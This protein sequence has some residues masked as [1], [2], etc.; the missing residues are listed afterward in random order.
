M[1]VGRKKK[2]TAS[3]EL[4]AE[5][6]ESEPV[7]EDVDAPQPP[8][9]PVDRWV[10][11]DQSRDWRQDGP[12]D[13]DEV[14]LDA[15]EIHRLDFGSL[16]LTPFEG[17][18]VQVQLDKAT[19]RANALLVMAGSS[20]VEISLFASPE[21]QTI[22]TDIRSDMIRA[23]QSA[24]G[25]VRLAEGPFGTEIRRVVPLNDPQGRKVFHISRTWLAEGP[26]WMLRGVVM[27]EAARSSGTDGS[28]ELLWEFFSNIVVRRDREPRAPGELIPMILPES[29]R[30]NTEPSQGHDQP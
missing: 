22:V 29:M 23:T 4:A 10:E 28:T 25:E 27:G 13:I 14:D 15:D 30:A 6:R 1:I 8:E 12:F 9:E 26:R 21:T 3:D 19:G 17:M 7:A 16:V 2:A 20:A 11:L 18:Q 5:T 24:G